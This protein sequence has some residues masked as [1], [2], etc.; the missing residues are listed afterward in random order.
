[1]HTP[2]VE[3]R[4]I[5]REPLYNGP[6]RILALVIAASLAV[7]LLAKVDFVR[8]VK[9]VLEL[10]CVRCHDSVTAMKHLRLDRKDRAMLVI[11]PGK[12]DESRLFLAAQSGYMPPGGPALSTAEL[13]TLR[14]WIA[15]GARWPN[16]IQLVGRNPFDAK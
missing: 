3:F 11:V 15:E 14:R 16:K 6:M 1:V 5:L 4:K 8:E 2:T 12:P 9:P 10:R 7:P 13:E